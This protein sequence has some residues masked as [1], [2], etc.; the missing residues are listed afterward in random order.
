MLIIRINFRPTQWIYF[1]SLSIFHIIT[2]SINCT[3]SIALADDAPFPVIGI[4][5]DLV[6]SRISY[7]G[8]PVV[9]IIRV[10]KL[11]T[12]GICIPNQVALIV[13]GIT[14]SP[15]YMT[16]D[17][18]DSACNIVCK[19]QFLSRGISHFDKIVTCICETYLIIIFI[20]NVVQLSLRRKVILY[21]VFPCKGKGIIWIFIQSIIYIQWWGV[22]PVWI[23]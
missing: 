4:G 14:P 15:A 21:L 3:K 8:H 9:L 2:K 13:V 7:R 11:P 10:A 16:R 5:H 19:N 12:H 17:R 1:S 22:S 18:D 23:R 6:P 20:D